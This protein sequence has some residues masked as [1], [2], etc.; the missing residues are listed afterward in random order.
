MELPTPPETGISALPRQ[1]G[2]E[3]GRLDPQAQLV[4]TDQARLVAEASEGT[5]H[6]P[7]RRR[8]PR[9]GLRRHRNCLQEVGR[10]RAVRPSRTPTPGFQ[11]ATSAAWPRSPSGSAGTAPPAHSAWTTPCPA[12]T[13]GARSRPHL[14]RHHPRGAR[15]A[16]AA[17]ESAGG[18]RTA[19]KPRRRR[20]R[21]TAARQALWLCE[22]EVLRLTWDPAGAPLD[23]QL[24]PRLRAVTTRAALRAVGV[25]PPIAA[26]LRRQ[27]DLIPEHE[28]KR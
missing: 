7:A 8:T 4:R 22:A 21:T 27:L 24:Q 12:P 10:A 14:G 26:A 5:G 11:T 6:D 9:C 18:M 20:P 16:A 19:A 1:A 23:S 2:H 25:L 15:P 17:A 3:G 13:P 28:A